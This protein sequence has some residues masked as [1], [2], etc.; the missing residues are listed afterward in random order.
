[1]E[2]AE[3]GWCLCSIRSQLTGLATLRDAD[4]NGDSGDWWKYMP[5][6]KS[7]SWEE[8]GKDEIPMVGLPRGSG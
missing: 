7:T 5:Y 2:E 4:P 3:S 1:M 6:G 8:S